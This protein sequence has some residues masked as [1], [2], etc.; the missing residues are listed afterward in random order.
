MPP[1]LSQFTSSA[2]RHSAL[3]FTKDS[4]RR[5]EWGVNV[6]I[7]HPLSERERV[8]R[9]STENVM[10]WVTILVCKGGFLLFYVRTNLYNDIRRSVVILQP[11]LSTK[12]H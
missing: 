6:C 3:T 8:P 11:D 10:S 9:V 7:S 2:C 1:S 4:N 5:W 12:Q